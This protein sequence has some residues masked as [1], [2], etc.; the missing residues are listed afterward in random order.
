MRVRVS[1]ERTVFHNILVAVD[2]SAHAEA[3]LAQAIDLA[4]SEHSRLTLMTAV[5]K[6]APLAYAGLSYEG[7]AELDASAESWAAEVLRHARDR[8]PQDLPVE[9]T[10]TTRPIRD[11]LI[12]QA[13]RGRH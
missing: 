2:G 12:E 3:A 10:L 13:R 11:A 1:E 6:V 5:Q 9:T 7:C 4:E 8:I